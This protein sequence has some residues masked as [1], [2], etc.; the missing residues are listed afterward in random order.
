MTYAELE[1]RFNANEPAIVQLINRHGGE[2]EYIPHTLLSYYAQTC[3]PI[4]LVA[5][6]DQLEI[7]RDTCEIMLME[8]RAKAFDIA[9]RQWKRR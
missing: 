7:I 9:E 4:Q 2:V 6:K 3:N 8:A 5:L 1:L